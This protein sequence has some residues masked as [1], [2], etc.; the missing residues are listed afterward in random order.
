M[1][2]KN[3]TYPP[4]LSS[5]GINNSSILYQLSADALHKIT[6]QSN[7]GVETSSGAL[8]V[9][10]GE[11]T[12]RSPMDRFIVKDA[13]TDDKVWWGAVNI[14][15]APQDFDRLYDRV[16]SYLEEKDLYVR[17]C[18]ACSEPAH[19]MRLRVVNEYPWSNMFAFN[20]FIRPSDDEHGWDR[21]N[22]IFNFEGGCYAK[23][24]NLSGED[25]PEIFSAI[26]KGALLENV[27]VD[28]NG[29][30][31]YKD[32]SITQNTRVS[33]PINHIENIKIPSVASNP[34]NIFFLTAD[35]FCVLPPISKLTANQSAYH[36]ISGYTAKV[37]GTEAGVVE[38]TPS[39]SANRIAL[40]NRESSPVEYSN[41][42]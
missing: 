7:Q 2:S 34:K 10:T 6:L 21:L 26:K 41:S 8:A 37:A 9:N 18:F 31:E 23:V 1:A 33:Y 12:G 42:F 3:K 15:F 4:S 36:F 14:P 5:L 40:I 39:F 16:I 11:F 17:D 20:M 25:E 19:Q 13:I 28:E 22:S 35:A 38:P 24:I 27:I 32:D 30:V 29:N